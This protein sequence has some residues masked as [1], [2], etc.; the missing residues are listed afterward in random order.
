MI[1]RAATGR[2]STWQPRP[3]PVRRPVADAW[4][5]FQDRVSEVFEPVFALV[6]RIV[7]IARWVLERIAVLQP[8]HWY[9]WRTAADE[10]TCPECGALH[11]QTWRED[12]PAPAP[13]L[14]VSCRCAIHLARTEWRVRSVPTWR[15]RTVTRQDW[16]WRRTGWQ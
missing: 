8:V 10:R 7:R 13:P 6:A 14:H 2:A 9:A 16:E 3:N 12:Q 5:T 15:L 4:D 1:G 11:G